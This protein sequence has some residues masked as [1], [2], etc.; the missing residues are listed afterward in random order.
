[1]PDRECDVKFEDLEEM[2]PKERQ[3]ELDD[4]KDAGP[5][6]LDTTMDAGVEDAGRYA[7][8]VRARLATFTVAAVLAKDLYLAYCASSDWKNF[9][10]EPCPPWDDLPETVRTHWGAVATF[11]LRKFR[12][13]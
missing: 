10:G 6:A 2:V 11:V 3:L 5:L 12:R 13:V 1:M 8:V 9:Q 7:E 4:T